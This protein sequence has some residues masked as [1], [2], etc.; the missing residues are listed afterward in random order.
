MLTPVLNF[1]DYPLFLISIAVG[2]ALLAA[3]FWL[4]HRAHTDLGT[5][6]SVSLELR[7][8]HQVITQGVYRSIRHP[9][10][11]AIFLYALAQTFLLANWIAGPSCLVA[12]TLMFAWRIRAEERMMRDRF[13]Q[14]YVEY[15]A[16]TK[17]LIPRV[18]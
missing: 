13:G 14:A 10:Y 11:T 17:R 3:T 1:A 2:L 4:F 7:E 8:N 15:T 16:A 5:N 18:W 12:F 6:W 9:M